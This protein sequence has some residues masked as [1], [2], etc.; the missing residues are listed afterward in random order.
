VSDTRESPSFEVMRQLLARGGD[1]VYC[2]PGVPGFELDGARH[3]SVQWSVSELEHADCT[4]L[5]TQHRQFREHALWEHAQLVV[6]TR[7]VVPD[8]PGVHR[9]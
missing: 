7:N 5:L 9:I 8:G 4:V 2:D 6:D 1:V 3:E